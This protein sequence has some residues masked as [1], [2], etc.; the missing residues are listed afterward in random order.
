MTTEERVNL[1]ATDLSKARLPPALPFR[2]PPAGRD[3]HSR[4]KRLHTDSLAPRL[5]RCN[6]SCE[7]RVAKMTPP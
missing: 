7:R 6:A 4:I 5:A 1:T 3:P 2:A